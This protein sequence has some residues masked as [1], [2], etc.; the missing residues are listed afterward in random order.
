MNLRVIASFPGVNPTR[1]RYELRAASGHE[2]IA[3]VLP[4]GLV[5]LPLLAIALSWRAF[6][7][8]V[9][10]HLLESGL[11]VEMLLNTAALVAGVCA[12]TAAI[13]VPLG[14]LV[15]N[16]RFPGASMVEWLLV[17]PMA[18]PGYVLGFVFMVI[19]DY[20]GPVQGQ[21][22]AWFSEDFELPEVR[23]LPMAI[24]VLSLTLYPYVYLLARAGFREQS[25]AQ[26]DIARTLGYTPF[27]VFWRVALPLARPSLV[28]GLAFVVMETLTDFAVVR[29][30]NTITLSEGIVR[31]WT[32]QLDREA[33]TQLASLLMVIALAMVLIERRLRRRQRYSQLGSHTRPLQLQPLHG[34]RGWAALCL[35]LGV[36][37]L[38]FGVPVAQLAAWAVE[39]LQF[40]TG[41]VLGEVLGTYLLNTFSLAALAALLVILVAT[42]IAWV[43]RPRN[44][45][46]SPLVRLLA[47]V[48]MLG[49]A[50]PGAVVAVGILLMLS[51]LNAP[52]HTL[53]GGALVLS[54]SVIGLMYGYVVRFFAIGMNSI[55]ASAAKITPS[56]E[57][58][59]RVL[60]AHKAGVLWRVYL[61]LMRNGIATAALL[62]CV[63][64]I[65]ELPLTMFLRPFG[66]DTLSIWTY[67]Q[68]SESAWTSA[69]LPALL[70]IA[71]SVAP[72][73]ILLR[74]S[75]IYRA[76][77]TT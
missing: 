25:A 16:Y 27:Q 4:A 14:W 29:Y 77:E 64:V 42:P 62:V 49:Y 63:D 46:V 61:P 28:A 37:A 18:V 52:L 19:F 48:A 34:W 67:M 5:V 33:A 9:W 45:T 43:M 17:L 11:L 56:M 60:G 65:K 3:A 71:T 51:P 69:A 73:L 68:A 54:G 76:E 40:G 57:M 24:L 13:G 47:R 21:L 32:G 66:M 23:S 53:S 50:M 30:Y 15:A 39:D 55:E 31:L 8:R 26:R 59:A 36:F 35:A 1:R 6:D 12:L 70:I 75:H 7:A 74:T 44:G 20:A 58:A 10:S 2:W 72:A 22:R 41:D 38:A